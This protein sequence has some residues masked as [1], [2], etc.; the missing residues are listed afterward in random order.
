MKRF[1][2]LVLVAAFALPLAIGCGEEAKKTP[3]PAKTDPAKA[4]E[5]PKKT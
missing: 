2:S 4:P 3:T 1:L 5:T